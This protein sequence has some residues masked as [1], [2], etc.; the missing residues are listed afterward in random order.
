MVNECEG[1]LEK[2]RQIDQ[3]EEEIQR[4]KAKLRYQDKNER[5]K[6]GVLDLPPLLPNYLSK[7]TPLSKSKTARGERV[8]ATRVTVVRFMLKR[9][10][11]KSFPWRGEKPALPVE[12]C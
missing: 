8:P 11:M 1:C 10:L 6:K 4:L 2:Q 12:E 9:L 5:N 3:L 7:P